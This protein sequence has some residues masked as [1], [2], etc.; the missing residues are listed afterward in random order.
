MILKRN[1]RHPLTQASLPGNGDQPH[2]AGGARRCLQCGLHDPTFVTTYKL[3]T[4][5]GVDYRK[6]LEPDG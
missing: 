2:H 4:A 3:A 5:P 1:V 6:L